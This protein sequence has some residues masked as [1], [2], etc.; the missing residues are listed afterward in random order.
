[1][2]N[3]ETLLA[4]TDILSVTITPFNQS[5]SKTHECYHPQKASPSFLPASYNHTSEPSSYRLQRWF[6]VVLFC[7]HRASYFKSTLRRNPTL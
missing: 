1:M 2:T 4:I 7:I 3:S 6:T 5:L